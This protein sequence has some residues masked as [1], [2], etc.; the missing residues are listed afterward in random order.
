MYLSVVPGGAPPYA[1]S[2]EIV[3]KLHLLRQS[4]PQQHTHVMLVELVWILE[5]RLLHGHVLARCK[6]YAVVSHERRVE[7]LGGRVVMCGVQRGLVVHMLHQE[8]RGL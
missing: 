5:H 6:Y 3:Q 1:L 4:V 2:H 8:G 7:V